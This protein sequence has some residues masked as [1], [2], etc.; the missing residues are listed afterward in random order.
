MHRFASAEHR[1]A[2]VWI[3]VA[4]D[5]P[6]GKHGGKVNGI[7]YLSRA[8][9]PPLFYVDSSCGCIEVAMVIL[10]R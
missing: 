5:K 6:D 8:Y 10:R 1:K 3:G 9:T 2:D 4:F 7:R